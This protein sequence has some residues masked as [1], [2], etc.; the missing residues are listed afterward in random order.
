NWSVNRNKLDNLRGANINQYQLDYFV[1][2]EPVGTIKGYKV[3]GIIQTQEEIDELNANSPTGV[4]DKSSTGIGDYLYEDLDGD[5]RITSDDRTVI[6]DV[7]PDFFGGF[8]TS[9]SYKNFSLSAFFQY[10]VGAESLWDGIPQGVSNILGSNKYSE[11]AVKTWPPDNPDARY[12]KAVYFDPSENGRIS[13]RYMFD[14]S[15]LRFKS[16]QVS[17]TLDTDFVKDMGINHARF[18]L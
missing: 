12:A 3:K 9:F 10:S 18:T 8:S 4:Y 5:G 14:S 16:L 11:Y 13:D 2:G 7:E 15:Y 1:E 6:G 17:Y